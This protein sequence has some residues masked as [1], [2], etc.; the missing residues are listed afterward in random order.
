MLFVSFFPGLRH[1]QRIPTFDLDVHPKIHRGILRLQST[2]KSDNSEVPEVSRY[3]DDIYHESTK[4]RL[5]FIFRRAFLYPETTPIQ[6]IRYG[7]FLRRFRVAIVHF[8]WV[9]V[10]SFGLSKGQQ[11]LEQRVVKPFSLKYL[12]RNRMFSA[13]LFNHVELFLHCYR[14]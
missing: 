9:F 13:S 14:R 3:L 10:I 6:M 5:I 7:F 11:I 8:F 12:N 1:S 4:I 2:K